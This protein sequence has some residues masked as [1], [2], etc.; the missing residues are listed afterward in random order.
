M[1]KKPILFILLLFSGAALWAAEPSSRNESFDD[2]FTEFMENP[3]FQKSR[4]QFPLL[5]VSVSME[6][7]KKDTAKVE[8][9][10]WKH[11]DFKQLR[12]GYQ[13]R[14]FDNFE[15]KLRDTDERV[16]SMIGNDNGVYYSYF[17]KRVEG[18]WM[19]VQVLDESS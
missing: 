5:S 18:R 14:Q 15:R 17:F 19:L 16:V 4:I 7:E 11:N 3:E 13:V 1:N 10:A 6:T 12:T 8:R 9:A 2:F